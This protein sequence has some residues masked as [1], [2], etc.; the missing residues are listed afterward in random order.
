VDIL[1]R[2]VVSVL[3]TLAYAIVLAGEVA[4]APAPDARRAVLVYYGNDTLADAPLSANYAALFDILRR[5]ND[6]ASEET[7]ETLRHDARR[8][9]EVITRDIEVLRTAA[10]LYNLEFFAFTNE[11]AI[12]GGFLSAG[13]ADDTATIRALPFTLARGSSVLERSPL[14]RADFLLHALTAV[15]GT[16]PARP[17]DIHLIV[18]THG[19]GELAM[20]PRVAA[21]FTTANADAVLAQ[22]AN[23]SNDLA[24]PLQLH[25][26]RKLELW[27]TISTLS[28]RHDLRFP[29]IF[30]ES[31]DSGP[32]EWNEYLA[33]P[34]SVEILA[35]SGTSG[36]KPVEIEY[37]GLLDTA[38]GSARNAGDFKRALIDQLAAK[39]VQVDSRRSLWRW[40]AKTMLASIPVFWFFLPL[41]IWIAA[42][43]GLAF[44][45]R[46]RAP[47]PIEGV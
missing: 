3:A 7:A 1:R 5:K 22:L 41:G 23:E 38:G 37:T 6:A 35:H 26:T 47:R 40:P 25:G 36:L 8:S 16:A 28:S 42:L 13:P 46:L 31:C 32:L 33:I 15:I 20:M 39:G 4:A 24:L 30:M 44:A 12:Q 18:N 19:T 29:V 10:R 11:L 21:D 9:G 17:H 2:L 27:D 34:P 14:S 43:C 45:R